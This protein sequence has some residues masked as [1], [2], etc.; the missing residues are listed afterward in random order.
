[1]KICFWMII[2]ASITRK[3]KRKDLPAP[4]AAVACSVKKHIIPAMHPAPTAMRVR[5]IRFVYSSVSSTGRGAGFF[6]S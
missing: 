1:M 6:S 4:V 3:G 5:V 2:E